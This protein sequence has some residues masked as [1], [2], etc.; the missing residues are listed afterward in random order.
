M[1]KDDWIVNGP[2]GGSLPLMQIRAANA[3]CF[4]LN[5]YIIVTTGWT[6][7]FTNFNAVRFG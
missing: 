3:C 2:R 6:I 1:S 7:D 5:D 4:D